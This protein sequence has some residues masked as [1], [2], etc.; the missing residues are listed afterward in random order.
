MCLYLALDVCTVCWLCVDTTVN[1]AP[2][3]VMKHKM[4]LVS[5]QNYHSEQ[6]KVS[7]KV[8]FVYIHI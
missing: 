3:D 4:I 6:F 2:T 5:L 1:A 7:G 8:V